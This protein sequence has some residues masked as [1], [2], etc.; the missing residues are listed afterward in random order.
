MLYWNIQS[1]GECRKK[2]KLLKIYLKSWW[3]ICRFVCSILLPKWANSWF[4]WMIK[5]LIMFKNTQL[6]Q[7]M[8]YAKILKSILDLFLKLVFISMPLAYLKELIVQI[9]KMF[10]WNVNKSLCIFVLVEKKTLGIKL[11]RFKQS[12]FFWVIILKTVILN[13]QQNNITKQFIVSFLPMLRLVGKKGLH[14]RIWGNKKFK[15]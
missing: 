11:F 8:R 7:L 15:F 12:F 3:E 2:R 6:L 1:L 5:I 4:T 14:K 13:L 9:N 10:C